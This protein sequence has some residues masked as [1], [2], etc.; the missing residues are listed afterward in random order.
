MHKQ[1]KDNNNLKTKQPEVTENR[2]VWKSNNQGLK[3]ETFIQTGRR[4]A[5][6]QR[7]ERTR[8]KVVAGGLS[9]VGDCGVRWAKL[10]LAC[11]AAAGGPGDRLRN[12][13]FQHRE[14]KPQTSDS[15]HT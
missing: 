8:G 7:V 5:A 2:T 9:E 13:G 1:K 4:G 15:K 12:P 10:Q 6:R 3:E 14:I 11:K